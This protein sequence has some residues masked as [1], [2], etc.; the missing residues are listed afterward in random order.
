LTEESLHLQNCP[1]RLRD[2]D[3]QVV[4]LEH[5]GCTVERKGSLTAIN[6]GKVENTVAPYDL[7]RKMRGSILVLGPLLARF[8]KATVSL[9]GGCAI[10]TRPID[11]HIQGLKEMGA[12]I[13]L[14]G[15]Y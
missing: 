4:L 8:G 7:V 2:I 9:P 5:L 6:A 12:D 15:G 3:A 14:E 10:G 13:A 11:L 1:N